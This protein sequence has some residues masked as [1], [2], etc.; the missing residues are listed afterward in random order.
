MSYI[1]SGIIALITAFVFAEFSSI[2]PK[3]GSSYIYT[4]STFGE[5]PAWIV[6]WNQNLR[7]GGSA[8]C[9]SRGFSKFFMCDFDILKLIVEII[10]F[11]KV[12]VFN[13]CLTVFSTYEKIVESS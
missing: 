13:I 6:G 12:N 3:S 10:Q 8:A 11:L 7:Y 2:I 9:L 1:I 5:L 4:Y